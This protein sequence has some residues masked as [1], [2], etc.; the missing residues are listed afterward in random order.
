MYEMDS[1][2]P[3][4]ITIASVVEGHGEVPALPI[5]L[6]RVVAEILGPQ[7]LIDIPRPHRIPKSNLIKEGGK[8]EQAVQ[9][10][11]AK[12][13]EQGGILVLIDADDDCP[14]E[15]GPALLER[16]IDARSDK[17][18]GVV[19]AKYE[20]EAWFLAAAKSLAGTCGLSQ[21]LSMP[22]NPEGIKGAKR[23]LTKNMTG[24]KAYSPTVDQP[25]L[26]NIFDLGQARN[27]ASSF[28]KFWRVVESI[29]PTR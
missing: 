29:L 16:C 4:K 5:L 3:P 15:L 14:A 12:V 13:Q 20:F 18:L 21:S 7:A 23:W 6:R 11:A 2:P 22:K 8:L 9:F 28:D 19:V 17:A 26:A 1:S 27:N 10:A 24:S 25:V